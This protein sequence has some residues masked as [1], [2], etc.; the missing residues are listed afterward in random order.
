MKADY[1]A[2]PTIYSTWW[3]CN[4]SELK[5]I[6]FLLQWTFIVYLLYAITMRSTRETKILKFQ[7]FHVRD[8]KSSK[9]E[10]RWWCN[11][12]FKSMRL[13]VVSNSSVFL[14]SFSY[15]YWVLIRCGRDYLM[16][17]LFENGIALTASLRL[18]LHAW[19]KWVGLS[20]E[21]S[22]IYLFSRNALLAGIYYVHL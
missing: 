19:E 18:C 14:F 9:G 5:I 15:A 8:L 6:C 11:L 4:I 20:P 1:Q 12:L 16:N 17:K 10:R 22:L 13:I 2:A 3:F 7:A 21:R